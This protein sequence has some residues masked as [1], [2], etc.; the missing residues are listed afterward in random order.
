MISEK[1]TSVSMPASLHVRQHERMVSNQRRR[2]V[3]PGSFN[4]L[5]IAHLEIARQARTQH[6]LDEVHL[7]VSTVALDKP[8]PPGP[9]FE[10]RMLL[11]E[12]DAAA[13]DWLFVSTSERQLI[14]DIAEG[15]D[16]V[17]MGADKWH[18]VNDESYYSSTAERDAALLRLPQVAVAP[19]EGSTTPDALVMHTP[20]ELHGVSSTHA[21]LGRR[22]LMAPHAAAN[23]R[24]DQPMATERTEDEH[25]EP[26]P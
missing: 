16:I 5:T 7:V 10:E 11:L 25:G 13:F 3:F 8:A 14:V 15:Y 4:P 23:W 1:F 18:Q 22:D 20:T 9:S 17:I 26:K 6:R 2:G 19:R 12:A 21:R 24:G